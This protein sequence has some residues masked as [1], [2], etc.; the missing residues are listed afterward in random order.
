MDMI[1]NEKVIERSKIKDEIEIVQEEIRQWSTVIDELKSKL[2]AAEE[3]RN[4]GIQ[5]ML[6]LSKLE[7]ETKKLVEII[8]DYAHNLWD[9]CLDK[10]EEIVQTSSWIQ[11]L[12]YSIKVIYDQIETGDSNSNLVLFNELAQ[13]EQSKPS[14]E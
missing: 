2:A 6:D 14:N 5:K 3:Q 7:M 11:R 9:V 13:L 8:P 4:S 1:I 10:M 12:E